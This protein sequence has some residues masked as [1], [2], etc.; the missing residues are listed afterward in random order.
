MIDPRT[1]PLALCVAIALTVLRPGLAQDETRSEVAHPTFAE[2]RAAGAEHSRYLQPQNAPSAAD[3]PAGP[4]LQGFAT[5]IE[6]ILRRNCYECHGPEEDEG[7]V[8][9]DTMDPDLFTGEDVDWWIDVLAVL[10]NGEM[11]PEDGP[12]LPGEDRAK[13]ID[14]LSIETQRASSTRRAS[15]AHSSF[16][17]LTRYEYDYALQDLLGLPYDFASELPPDPASEDG[18]RNSSETLHLAGSQLRTCLGAGRRALELATVTGDRPAP[19]YWSVSMR[20]LA[21]REWQGQDQQLDKVRKE[22]AAD[23]AKVEEEVAKLLDRFRSPPGGTWFED[24]ETGRKARQSWGYNEARYART[25]SD[26]ATEWPPATGHVA[27]VTPRSSLTIELG[28]RV[29]DRG[30]LRVR[31]RASRVSTDGRAPRMRLIFGWQASND[32]RSFIEV[33]DEDVVVEAL[34]DAPAIYTFEVPLSQIYPRNLVRGVNKLGDL[35]SPSELI[36][37]QHVGGRTGPVRIDHVEIVAPAYEQWP[38]ASHRRLLPE[39]AAD[40]AERDYAERVLAAFLPRA[41]RRTVT[42]DE[43]E[44]KLALFDEVRPACDSLQEAVVEVFAAALASPHFLYLSTADGTADDPD[45]PAFLS[46]EELASRLSILLWC[47]IPDDEL[48]ALAAEGRLHEP[49]I[50]AAQVTR[51][52]ADPRSRRFAQHFVHQWLNL[53]LLEFLQVDRKLYKGF[54]AELK[55][56]MLA[57]PVAFFDELLRNDRS[58]LDVLHADYAVVNE[59]L[60]R[61]YGWEGIEGD[62]FR[63]VPVPAGTRRGGLLTQAGLLAMNSNGEDSHPIKRAVWLLERILDDPPPPPPPAVPKIDLADPEIAKMTLKERLEDHRNQAACMSCHSKID[64]WGFAFENFDAVGAW[65]NEVRG[66]PVDASG[67]LFNGQRLEGVDGLKR[68]LLEQRQDQLVRAMVEKLAAFALGR[69]LV[70]GDRAALDRITAEVRRRGDGLATL[71]SVLV[72]SEL[73]RSR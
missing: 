30:L 51:M 47:S 3:V 29:A 5:T 25:P 71:V 67:T 15:R 54:D 62:E 8:R 45:G 64:A 50:L 35:P 26:A 61:H 72:Q 7:G 52:R 56:A 32:S 41:W 21:A 13:V 53:E 17:R 48:R 10:T 59:R 14:W 34:P 55:A 18:F 19:L 57:E 42:R 38:P 60:A 46:D 73:F 44:R 11:P 27:V 36:R 20:D 37:L 23:P 9:L 63:V 2:A 24:P 65:R 66:R 28:D 16:R 1:L 43:V 69:P 40:E 6:P 4:D 58:V 31:F 68:F 33:S 49:E 22:H 70:F 12:K 39:R